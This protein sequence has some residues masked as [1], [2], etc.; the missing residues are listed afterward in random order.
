MSVYSK[1]TVEKSI[2]QFTS[3]KDFQKMTIKDR[4]INED[5]LSDLIINC[6]P[7]IFYLQ[8]QYGKYL[9]WNKNFEVATG[10]SREEIAK[11]HPLDFFDKKDHEHMIAA[12]R[13]VYKEGYNETEAE[14]V[15]KNGQRYLY[16]LNG[17][18]VTYEGKLCLFGTG[19]DLTAREKAQREIEEGSKKYR[20][21]FEQASDPILVTDLDGNITDLNSSFSKLFGYSRKELLRMNV[22]S[23]MC[24]VQTKEHPL[25]KDLLLKGKHIF[26]DRFMVHKNGSVVETEANL[27]KFGDDRVMGIIRDV[28][29]IRKMQ[30]ELEEQRLEQQV[31]EQ[32]KINRA[33]IKA[34]ERERN[35]IGRELHDNVNQLLA[36]TRMCLS[37]AKMTAAGKK[38]FV[39]KSIRLIDATIN[40]I[41]ILSK[42]HVT[43]MKGF[44]LKEQIQ[45]LVKIMEEGIGFKITFEYDVKEDQ[46]ILN[47]LKLNVY[48]IIQEQLNNVY[49]HASAS[50]AQV[51]MRSAKDQ[52]YISIYDNGIGFEAGARKNG[53]GI[54]NIVNRVESFN[55]EASFHTQPGV[56]CKLDIRI[57]LLYQKNS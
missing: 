5:E 52:I 17:V 29:A 53:V 35:I 32:K 46:E 56:G 22:R 3:L 49:K 18:A 39:D 9:R 21:L 13:K 24:P 14:V 45:S 43:P 40:E 19:F 50:R 26:S 6:L 34:Q 8:D 36:S 28:T 7:G 57:P 37:T 12:T 55:G 20:A 42:K 2:Q 31:Q 33:V 11:M 15:I 10:Y 1:P 4:L 48:R 23:L 41:R 38:D 27:K 16:Y 54:V 44:D 30:R 51:K 47:D 25:R